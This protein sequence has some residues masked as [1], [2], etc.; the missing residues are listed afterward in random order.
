MTFRSII[1]SAVVGIVVWSSAGAAPAL[2]DC[3]GTNRQQLP[4]LNH[5]V[6][7]WRESTRDQFQTRALV[8]GVITDIYP[9]KTGHAHFAINLD[10]EPSGDIEI[11]YNQEF[12]ALPSL[13]RGMQV[14]ACGDYI[15][16]GPRSRLPSPMGAI[17]HWV[18]YN[19]GNR[20]GGAHPHGYVMV[21]GMVY[22]FSSELPRNDF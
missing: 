12:G 7:Q 18:H 17:I 16:A 15:T 6:I 21:N 1:L 13:K 10:S 2:P 3:F 14:V 4:I 20:D 19:P 11:I 5:Q 8:Q 22:G 9:E